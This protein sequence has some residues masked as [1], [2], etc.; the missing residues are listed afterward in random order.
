MGSN[1]NVDS[2]MVTARPSAT[3]KDRITALDRA[4]AAGTPTRIAGLDGLRGLA[5]TA[6]MVFHFAPRWLPGGFVGVD[7][8]YVL[9][10]YLITTLLL[11]DV[12]ADGRLNLVGFWARRAR[13]LLPCLVLVL[14][15]VTAYVRYVAPTG[16]YPG[17]RG[18]RCRRSSSFPTGTRSST[19]AITGCPP[20][21]SPRSSIRGRWPSRSSSTWPG[22]SLSSASSRWPEGYAE[23]RRSSSP[24]AWSAWWRRPPRWHCSIS[25]TVP[26]RASIS[27]PTPTPRA[28]S[29]EP[30]W[31]ARWPSSSG[32]AEPTAWPPSSGA[33]DCA[34]G[35]P[36]S[37]SAAWWAWWSCRA[38]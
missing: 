33:G 36:P 10:G 3:G 23:P 15:A 1:P 12:R 4:G 13:R 19:P 26:T 30:P 2:A 27:G 38:S 25:R 35:S 17:Y 20:G 21:P 7:V 29:W 11:V 22:P 37:G 28:C 34:G 6:V 9:S 18:T 8:F 31:P 24:V 14:L 16:T 5:V 32:A